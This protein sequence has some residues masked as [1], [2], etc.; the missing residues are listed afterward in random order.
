M[1]VKL[2][3]IQLVNSIAELVV[4]HQELKGLRNDVATR[5]RAGHGSLGADAPFG[6]HKQSG[7]DREKAEWGLGEFLEVNAIMGA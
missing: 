7:N 3:G 5:Q 4:R 2:L 6:G 1:K